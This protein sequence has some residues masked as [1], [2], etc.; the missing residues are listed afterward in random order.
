MSKL[1]RS[2]FS[3]IQY[4]Y[5]LTSQLES[6]RRFFEEKLKF[7]EDSTHERIEGLEQSNK[8]LKEHSQQLQATLDLVTKDKQQQEKR[9]SV[10]ITKLQHDYDEEK[11]MNEQLRQNQN[12]FQVE[13]QKLKEE[14][15]IAMQNKNQVGHVI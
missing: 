4:T 7:V 12:Y 15:N 14:F 1:N 13:M 10:K 3:L 9:S 5:L 11:L 6:Q 8:L 2:I